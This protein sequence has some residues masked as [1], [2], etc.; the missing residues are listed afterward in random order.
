M[1]LSLYSFSNPTP[2]WVHVFSKS[3]AN[4]SLRTQCAAAASANAHYPTVFHRRNRRARKKRRKQDLS[5]R[6][7][8]VPPNQV[9]YSITEID[10]K[11]IV[12]DGGLKCHLQY[13][14][15]TEL[16]GVPSQY[17][18]YTLKTSCVVILVFHFQELMGLPPSFDCLVKFY[19]K[20]Y[21]K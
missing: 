8:V 1:N 16:G 7:M 6:E 3:C 14:H 10:S 4:S 13:D 17:E 18:T 9:K 15:H 2:P 20:S 21:I 19:S 11:V 12:V 5:L